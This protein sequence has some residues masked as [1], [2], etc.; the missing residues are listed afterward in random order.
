[1]IAKAPR[2]LVVE[3][4][5]LSSCGN[6]FVPAAEKVVVQPGAFIGLHGTV[7][8]STIEFRGL[9]L[10]KFAP[11]LE[12]EAKFALE[13]SVA[14][15][16][17]LFRDAY[18]PSVGRIPTP[19]MEGELRPHDRSAGHGFLLVERPFLRSC[20]PHVEIVELPAYEQIIS[21]K[22][23]ASLIS[24]LGAVGTGT[25]VCKSNTGQKKEIQ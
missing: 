23:T 10:V 14:R 7:D 2:T 8:P 6:Y 13:F 15:G 16:W 24:Q 12:A 20:L 3:D 4:V 11:E 19:D 9:D 25:M 18:D 5:C 17:R 22:D 21:N 1:L